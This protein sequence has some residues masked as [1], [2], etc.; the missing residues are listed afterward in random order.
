M[1]GI[2]AVID[3]VGGPGAHLLLQLSQQ[4]DSS[5]IG[6]QFILLALWLTP[7]ADSRGWLNNSL[8]M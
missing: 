5:T 8:Q 6:E 3:D 1:E 7:Q 4:R 2:I